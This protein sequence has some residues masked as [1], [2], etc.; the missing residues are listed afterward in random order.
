[1]QNR[2]R[3]VNFESGSHFIYSSDL[4]NTE[5]TVFIIFKMTDIASESLEFVNSL[6][7][8]NNKKNQCKVHNVFQNIYRWS[9]YI[10]FKNTGWQLC[11][12]SN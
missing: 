3:Y 7:G 6:T 11:S 4:N 9:R 12:N 2:R 1:M 5:S 8:N 10:N